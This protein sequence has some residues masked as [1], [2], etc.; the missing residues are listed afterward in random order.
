[1]KTN[2]ILIS[3][4]GEGRQRPSSTVV[5]ETKDHAISLRFSRIA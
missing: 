2:P 4:L 3:L 1:M 5:C